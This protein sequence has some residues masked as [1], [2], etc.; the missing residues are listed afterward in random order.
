LNL[1]ADLLQRSGMVLWALYKVCVGTDGHVARV[2]AIKKADAEGRFGDLDREWMDVIRGWQF[3]PHVKDGQPT[4]FCFPHRV[5][6][7][8]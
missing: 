6:A 5:E 8:S 4:S 7:R 1:P 2:S 3:K